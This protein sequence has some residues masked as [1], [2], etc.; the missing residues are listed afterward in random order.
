MRECSALLHKFVLQ[1]RIHDKWKWLLDLFHGYSV[2]G[3]YH[4]FTTTDVPMVRN[5]ADDI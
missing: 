2:R 4:F 1:E 3:V 5:L